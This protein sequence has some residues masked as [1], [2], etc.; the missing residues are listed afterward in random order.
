VK[1][2]KIEDGVGE[3][4]SRS[5]LF[6]HFVMTIILVNVVAMCNLRMLV[7]RNGCFVCI[8]SPVLWEKKFLTEDTIVKYL[9]FYR[10]YQD[11]S[12]GCIV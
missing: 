5:M 11:Q 3:L 1:E 2:M 12:K 4:S 6:C 9:L 10:S 8:F 7:G